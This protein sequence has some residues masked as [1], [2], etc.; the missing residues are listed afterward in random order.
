MRLE[1]KKTM[2]DNI[3]ILLKRRKHIREQI[4]ELEEE[5][6]ALGEVLRE[7]MEYIQK[8]EDEKYDEENELPELL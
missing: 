7:L 1:R 3:D 4:N 2:K 6:G 8:E 5:Y